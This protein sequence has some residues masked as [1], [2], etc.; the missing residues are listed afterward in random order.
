MRLPLLDIFLYSWVSIKQDWWINVP[1]S[2]FNATPC[3]HCEHHSCLSKNRRNV[4]WRQGWF[5][6]QKAGVFTN[7]FTFIVWKG[8]ASQRGKKK[9]CQQLSQHPLPPGCCF[10]AGRFCKTNQKK[11]K[12]NTNTRRKG[13]KRKNLNYP[14]WTAY[15]LSG[16]LG[17]CFEM[18]EKLYHPTITPERAKDDI[19]LALMRRW[20]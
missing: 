1:T 7:K 3:V 16:C 11:T 14:D 5:L 13:K 10:D 17:V 2:W 19:A 8:G 18:F 12:C 6:G 15:P 4:S 9:A 20:Y